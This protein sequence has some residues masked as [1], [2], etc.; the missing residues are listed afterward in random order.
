M[1]KGDLQKLHQPRFIF[2][3]RIPYKKLVIASVIINAINIGGVL[4]L[5]KYIPPQIPLFYGL[6]EGEGQL[7]STLGL[8][9]PGLISSTITIFNTTLCLVIR[10]EEFLQKAL[11]VA[12]FTTSLL[13]IITVIQIIFLVGSF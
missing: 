9:I 11:V 2:F 5:S 12:A 10:K 13:S 7:N 8:I 4:L 3:A 1:A 6:A